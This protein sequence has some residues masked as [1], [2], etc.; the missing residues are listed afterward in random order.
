MDNKTILMVVV[1]IVLGMLVANMFKDVCGCKVVEGQCGAVGT[2]CQWAARA[3]GLPMI[4]DRSPDGSGWVGPGTQ[5]C[6]ERFDDMAARSESVDDWCGRADFGFSLDAPN[7]SP[8]CAPPPPAAPPPAAAVTAPR[9]ISAVSEGCLVLGGAASSVG[10]SV[11]GGGGDTRPQQW[12]GKVVGDGDFDPDDNVIGLGTCASGPRNWN[13][14]C[15]QCAD[16]SGASDALTRFCSTC[17][18]TD[19]LPGSHH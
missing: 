13:V 19:P 4:A 6:S 1:A 11:G 12:R 3:P 17:C 8:C 15:N 5:G 18:T 2:H 16:M 10:G 14:E 9:T 7:A